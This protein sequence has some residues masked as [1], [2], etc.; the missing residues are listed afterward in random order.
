[1]RYVILKN[2]V[3]SKEIK[4]RQEYLYDIFKVYTIPFFH[5]GIVEL[6]SVPKDEIDVLFVF[7]HNISVY[8]YLNNCIPHEDNIILITC[9]CGKVTTIKLDDKKMFYTEKITDRLDGTS[10]GFD[11]EITDAELNLYNC[12]SNLLGDKIEKCFKLIR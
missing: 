7:G 8:T 4:S 9:Y 5:D 11:F 12:K 1:M 10:Y 3:R 2:N 6:I